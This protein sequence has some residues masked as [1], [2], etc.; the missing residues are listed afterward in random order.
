MTED[1]LAKRIKYL[2]GFTNSINSFDETELDDL[3]Q[4]LY[5]NRFDVKLTMRKLLYPC[6]QLLYRCRW[7]GRMVDCKEMFRASET[8]QGKKKRIY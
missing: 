2:A 7:Q 8:Y 6:S 5:D 3:Y 4:I 1:E